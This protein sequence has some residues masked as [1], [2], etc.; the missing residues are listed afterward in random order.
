MLVLVA[1]SSGLIGNAVVADLRDAGHEVRRLVRRPAEADDEREWDPP[2]DVVAADAL[3]GVDAVVNLCGSAIRGRWNAKDKR[4]VRDSRIHATHVLSKAMAA[5]GVP[6]LLN[7]SSV[8]YYGNTGDVA[9][10]ESAGSGDGFL[11][12]M[13]I[14]WEGATAPAREA[15]VR[16]VTMRTGLVLSRDGG[17]L[18]QLR[19]MVRLGLGGKLGDGRQYV[20]WISVADV[21][22]AIRFLLTDRGLSGPV[23]LCAPDPVTNAEFTRALGRALRRP[24]FMTMPKPVVRMAFGD[25]ADELA[26]NSLRVVPT[27][28]LDAGF[29]FRHREFAA[30]LADVL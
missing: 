2:G 13:V 15:G 25:A 19:P 17:L 21:V 16:V 23:N 20:S 8:S 11:A 7:A 6:L 26:L 29:R 5:E 4:T 12:R 27:A 18:S 1:G 30:A 22:A 28:L 9:V 14:D 3:T 24:V 10:D